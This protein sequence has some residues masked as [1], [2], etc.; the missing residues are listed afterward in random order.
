MAKKS[1]NEARLKRHQRVRKNISGTADTPRLC[2]YR[3]LTDIYAQIIDESGAKVLVS[4]ST[5]E[6]AISASVKNGGN[7]RTFTVISLKVTFVLL[8]YS[9]TINVPYIANAKKVPS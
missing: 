1:R 5:A 7:V 9:D 2:V 8:V 6:K 3:S 4:A